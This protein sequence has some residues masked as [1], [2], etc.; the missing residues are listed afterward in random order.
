MSEQVDTGLLLYVATRAMESRIMR[1][2]ADAGFDITSAQARV[3]QNIE[4]GGSRLTTL[5]ERAV[6]SKQNAK[7]LVDQLE[8]GGY[9]ERTPDPSDRR[10]ILVRATAKGMA[11]VPV[12]RSAIDEILAEWRAHLGVRDMAELERILVKLRTLV[13]PYA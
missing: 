12:A 10:A 8:K 6:V 9:V 11:T 1:S 2:L 7:F 4:A 13:D 3:F 5:A